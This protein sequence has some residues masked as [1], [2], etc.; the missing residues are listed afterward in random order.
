MTVS[1][2]EGLEAE[3]PALEARALLAAA[4]AAVYPHVRKEDAERMWRGWT[5][6]AYP[7]PLA[8]MPATGS[9]L[10]FNGRP[11]DFQELKTRLSA[12]MEPGAL[13]A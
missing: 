1:Y 10:S 7:R 8:Q 3:I 9:L 12:A 2:F 11:V 5:D 4:Q 13:S 6:A